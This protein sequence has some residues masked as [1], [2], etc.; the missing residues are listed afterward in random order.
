MFGVP[1][2][3]RNDSPRSTLK[4]KQHHRKLVS[5]ESQIFYL[6]LSIL[7]Q[8]VTQP[9]SFHQELFELL[10]ELIDIEFFDTEVDTTSYSID[11]LATGGKE[12]GRMVV[13]LTFA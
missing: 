5:L 4:F 1:K 9:R 12:R 11:G 13:R 8:L 6:A 3:L 7:L 10:P 2:E